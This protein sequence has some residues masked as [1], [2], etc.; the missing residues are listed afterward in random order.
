MVSLKILQNITGDF[1]SA[2][3]DSVARKE[4]QKKCKDTFDDYVGYCENVVNIYWAST[5]QQFPL[6]LFVKE[7]SSWKQSEAESFRKICAE[8]NYI[9][10]GKN[11]NAM[12]WWR[13]TE[14]YP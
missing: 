13:V 5:I 9:A 6:E 1:H 3:S 4:L 7:V 10:V 8:Q 2:A 14:K 11:F 12:G